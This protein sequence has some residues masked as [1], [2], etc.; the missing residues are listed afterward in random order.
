MSSSA[1]VALTAQSKR[2]ASTSTLLAQQAVIGVFHALASAPPSARDDARQ[3]ISDCLCHTSEA[4]VEEATSRLLAALQAPSVITRGEAQDLLLNAAAA[5]GESTRGILAG[6]LVRLF[7]D[8]A[9]MLLSRQ[10]GGGGDDGS[11]AAAPPPAVVPA[12]SDHPLSQLLLLQPYTGPQLAA[13]AARA[14]RGA[15]VR[16]GG[17]PAA[18][19][20]LFSALSPFLS[21]VLLQRGVRADDIA[22]TAAGGGG[23]A[24]APSRSA[25][26]P[27]R[28]PAS[29]LL[30]TSGGYGEASSA[31]AASAAVAAGRACG[32]W[33][34]LPGLLTEELLA[35]AGDVPE[36]APQ[37]ARL[38]SRALAVA[39]VADGPQRLALP[40]AVRAAV[41]ACDVAD[42]AL[43]AAA[44]DGAA[45]AAAA[46]AQ[47]TELFSALLGL[48]SELS[49]CGGGQLGALLQ[50]LSATRHGVVCPGEA[51][52]LLCPL[53]DTATAPERA[54]LCALMHGLLTHTG[55]D[56]PGGGGGGAR[57]A[58]YTT[59]VDAQLAAVP[60]LPRLAYST[61]PSGKAHAHH[62]LTLMRRGA[63]A[64]P[65]RGGGGGG[66]GAR[67]GAAAPLCHG[68]LLLQAQASRLLGHR[69]GGNSDAGG[70]FGGAGAASARAW[71]SSLATQLRLLQAGGD[72]DGDATSALMTPLEPSREVLPGRQ[73]VADAR[74]LPAGA[75]AALG[76]LLLAGTADG[77][78][79]TEGSGGGVERGVTCAAA[80]ATRELLQLRPLSSL[81]VLPLLL[82][83]VRTLAT[84]AQQLQ[85]QP[86]QPQQPQQQASAAAAVSRARDAHALLHVLPSM[87][88]DA[89]VAP[90]AARAIQPLAAES[91][92]LIVRCVALRL[93]VQGWLT[94]GRGWARVEAAI[95]G[96]APHLAD[97]PLE[98]RLTRAALVRAV[99]RKDVSRGLELISAVQDACVDKSHSV[100][101]LGLQSLAAMCEQDVLDFYKAWGVVARAH[102][103]LPTP[104]HLAAAWVR[105]LGCGSADALTHPER[106]RAV[107]TAIRAAAL[108]PHASVRLEAADALACYAPAT[109][110]RLESEEDEEEEG[111]GGELI[112][113]PMALTDY[114][115][116]V[117]RLRPAAVTA[118]VN[119]VP[120]ATP[121]AA[122]APLT[123]TAL[124]LPG[125]AA[126]GIAARAAA[127]T[128]AAAA[129]AANAAAGA[130]AAAAGAAAAAAGEVRSAE[131]LAVISLAHEH[132]QRRRFL[133]AGA[134]AA[135]AAAATATDSA[136]GGGGGGGA[137]AAA[138]REA[139]SL[140]HRLLSSLPAQLAKGVGGGGPALLTHAPARGGASSSGAPSQVAAVS[141][142]SSFSAQLREG[143]RGGAMAACAFEWSHPQLAVATWRAF[144]ARWL[145]AL[146]D[147]SS[148]DEMWTALLAEWGCDN[149]GGAAVAPAVQEAAPLAAA[150]LACTLSLSLEASSPGLSAR[151]DSA[152]DACTATL[153]DA[154]APSAARASAAATVGVLCQL[155]HPTDTSG[156]SRAAA[157]LS[158]VVTSPSSRPNE[159]GA[160]AAALGAVAA[161]AATHGGGANGAGPEGAVARGALAA[162]LT[163]LS[164]AGGGQG[165]HLAGAAFA[166]AA[167]LP[168]GCL[169]DGAL[170]QEQ[171]SVDEDSGEE[172]VGILAGLATL[173]HGCGPRGTVWQPGGLAALHASLLRAAH[174]C[175]A[176]AATSQPWP[177]RAVGGAGAAA[178]ALRA[179]GWMHAACEG[180]G[181]MTGGAGGGGDADAVALHAHLPWAL[182]TVAGCAGIADGGAR[183]AAA[184]SLGIIL[185]AAGPSHAGALAA[186]VWVGGG[187]SGPPAGGLASAPDDTKLARRALKAVEAAAAPGGDGRVASSAVWLLAHACERFAATAPGTGG[188]GGSSGAG[189]GPR[190]HRGAASASTSST[191]QSQAQAQQRIIP[192]GSYPEAGAHRPLA[193]ALA[194]AAAAG[195]SSGEGAARLAACLRA[196]SRSPRLPGCDWG[197]VCRRLWQQASAA[198]GP[199]PA[200]VPSTLSGSVQ[201]Q[202]AVVRLCAAHGREA[203]HGL[204]VLVDELALGGTAAGGA[205]S[206]IS[207]AHPAVVCAA[208][209]ELP[210][211]LGCLAASRSEP[212]LLSLS[213]LLDAQ[214]AA[215]VGAGGAGANAEAGARWWARVLGSAWAGLSALLSQRGATAPPSPGL[216]AALA[217]A[218]AWL[219]DLPRGGVL[220]GEAAAMAAL[221]ARGSNSTV[222]W[223]PTP[224]AT[225]PDALAAASADE[226]ADEGDSDS[227]SAI[228]GVR[229]VEGSGEGT[230]GGS[231]GDAAAARSRA[232]VLWCQA[233]RCLAL[234][235]PGVA[236]ELAEPASRAQPSG[237]PQ[238]QQQQQHVML[239]G[240]QMR[241]L[242]VLCGCG[243]YSDLSPTRAA[244]LALDAAGARALGVLLAEA[245]SLAP[246]A[247]QSH[248]LHEAM[249]GA[250]GGG[251]SPARA[252]TLAAVL[253][254]S[255]HARGCGPAGAAS[256]HLCLPGGSSSSSSS[257]DGGGGDDGSGG[258]DDA[259]D[260]CAVLDWAVDCLPYS[261]PRLLQQPHWG[262]SLP[263]LSSDIGALLD[264]L[265]GR[266]LP[267]HRHALLAC[268]AALRGC[269]QSGATSDAV[270]RC[271]ARH[272]VAAV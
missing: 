224:G 91:A 207:R 241:C 227:G 165:G 119:V 167:A 149:G 84:A 138:A 195:H 136:A 260:G 38:L 126:A 147:S 181:L 41:L 100:A 186:Q 163:R 50:G 204:G 129:A 191:Q 116:P 98:L 194:D 109:V 230:G 162:L 29:A 254:G 21:F 18:A 20:R 58:P 142:S 47:R 182:A 106:A 79:N 133:N 250:Y 48:A 76:A 89:S 251:A 43:D 252:L 122:T 174:E 245:L 215:C 71:L 61:T 161:A 51:A 155:L 102:P 211:L 97:S 249:E 64:A 52:A 27:A 110:E 121:A 259:D 95:N 141:A 172:L 212:L 111:G 63:V 4:V 49:P 209:A 39:P 169:P 247:A 127:A 262:P 107:L 31:A 115:G 226:R 67:R 197:D 157:A 83:A 203:P 220:P 244:F 53:L 7:C 231:G 140:R 168:P 263:L 35:L 87:A 135:A 256:A 151:V 222:A 101:A 201:L 69:F 80:S 3:A 124:P 271:L 8:S 243:R 236:V 132:A 37:V 56:H 248:M 210:Q 150:G 255:W 74:D 180:A 128:T 137:A 233:A 104:P 77:S 193:R 65:A 156:R 196:L 46:N 54:Q 24:H 272:Y 264:L 240:C 90:F 2:L 225:L 40:A 123:S 229:S 242:L 30:H 36:V 234:T 185:T 268:L 86:Q 130:V 187:G 59:R 170:G 153:R 33:A 68:E 99:I 217:R 154:G 44:T 32:A 73:S 257:E 15:A 134:T 1:A 70:T 94:T 93:T 78:D 166:V 160:S 57:S 92:P 179:V 267:R 28:A 183:G 96:Y 125:S 261:L 232:L 113:P 205:G 235:G 237:E 177:P 16:G 143:L 269:A 188:S 246:V 45:A 82:S 218:A 175:A 146:G 219:P 19:A 42:E 213:A 239:R 11:G 17:G 13:A 60:L 9:L 158:L 105:L 238:Q 12:W 200:L 189:E 228:P 55:S 14:L 120:V 5:A 6:A 184:A 145:G 144:F 253:C 62:V 266:L 72:G 66:G 270:Y 199:T 139:A 221:V 152:L 108:H 148:P 34:L 223:L 214:H 88:Y 85:Q 171:A 202:V 265:A 112:G 164:R 26:W 114:V 192:L 216:R 159:R 258:D 208:L 131:A 23:G 25:A 176:A 178:A 75:E 198:A 206:A 190:A 81:R 173:L 117:L 103:R 118:S 10:E 22:A